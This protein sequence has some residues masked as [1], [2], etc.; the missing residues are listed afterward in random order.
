MEKNYYIVLGVSPGATRKRIKQAYRDLAKRFHPDG[1][2]AETSAA[3]FKEV[4][5]AYETLSDTGLRADYDK[6]LHHR[7][8]PSPQKGLESII[9]EHRAPWGGRFGRRSIVDEFFGGLVDR[10]YA[11]GRSGRV[12]KD[13]A[14]EMI[15]DPNEA[16]QGGL[17]PVGIPVQEPCAECNRSGFQY[18]FICPGCR[19]SGYIQS[20]RRFSIS[21]PP[22][23]RD[24]TEVILPLDDI[25]LR[26]IQLY[27]LIRVDPHPS[28]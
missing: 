6:K 2:G 20:E 17:F 10:P 21:V 23:T 16:H 14:V 18:P 15:L 24:G 4:Q 27:L 5:K 25:G 8:S 7:I 22:H 26:G 19:G 9:R 1:G 28:F 12:A 13:P 3:K 11:A